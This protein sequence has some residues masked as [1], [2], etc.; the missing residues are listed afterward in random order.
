MVNWIQLNNGPENLIKTSV[1][2]QFKGGPK[3]P[4]ISVINEYKAFDR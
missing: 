4:W 2:P 1:I 3:L